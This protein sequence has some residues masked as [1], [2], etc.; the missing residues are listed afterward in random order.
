M[1]FNVGDLMVFIPHSADNSHFEC[2][3]TYVSQIHLGKTEDENTITIT[4]YDI[5]KNGVHKSNWKTELYPQYILESSLFSKNTSW[6]YYPV[7]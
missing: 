5:M 1:N 2:S 7:K 6:K 3:I 4:T